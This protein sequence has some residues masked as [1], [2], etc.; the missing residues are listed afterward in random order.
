M[1]LVLTRSDW[2]DG[3][4]SLHRPDDDDSDP[5]LSG[6]STWG[7]YGGWMR[8]DAA[9]YALAE[10]LVAAGARRTVSIEDDGTLCAGPY[11]RISVDDWDVVLEAALAKRS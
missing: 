11:R 7:V 3:G 8:P 10:R 2:G 4:W 1:K 6:P 9:D 5:V